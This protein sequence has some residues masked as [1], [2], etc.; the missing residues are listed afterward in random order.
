MSTSLTLGYGCTVRVL[1]VVLAGTALR[2]V[3]GAIRSLTRRRV[4]FID[5]NDQQRRAVMP[6]NILLVTTI[7]I[8]CTVVQYD[9]YTRADRS[10]SAHQEALSPWEIHPT[11]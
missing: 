11:E 5:L 8:H 6:R 9:G 2:V 3:Y 7:D 4:R 1:T 10:T